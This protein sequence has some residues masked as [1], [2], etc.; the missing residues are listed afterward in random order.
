MLEAFKDSLEGGNPLPLSEAA[1]ILSLEGM[2][3]GE[4]IGKLKAAIRREFAG[5]GAA[6]DGWRVFIEKIGRTDNLFGHVKE[7]E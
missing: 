4:T 2:Y 5:E 7:D 1:N 6:V 3:A